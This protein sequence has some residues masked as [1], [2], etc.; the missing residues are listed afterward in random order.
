MIIRFCNL[1]CLMLVAAGTAAAENESRPA[2]QPVR[3]GIVDHQL[4]SQENWL[5]PWKADWESRKIAEQFAANGIAAEVIGLDTLESIGRLRT[6]QAILIPSDHNYPDRSAPAGPIA[7]NLATFVNQGGIYIMPFGAPHSSWRNVAG[8]EYRPSPLG[9][10]DFLGLHWALTA[11]HDVPG[12][13][14]K[15]APAGEKIALPKPTF[16]QPMATYCRV[17]TSIGEVYVTNEA[18]Q[19][20]LYATSVGH[21][22]VIHYPGGQPFGADVRDWLIA[23]YA[24]ILKSNI[25]F[26]ALRDRTAGTSTWAYDVL[27]V[28]ARAEKAA[29]AKDV[30]QVTLGGEWELAEAPAGSSSKTGAVS[31]LQWTHIQVPGTIQYALFQ[32]GKADN[33]WYADN[34]KKLQYVPQRDWYLR[35]TFTCPADWRGRHIRLRFDGM[36]YVGMVWLDGW[37]LGRHEGMAGGPTFDVTA[38]LTPGAEHEILVRLVHETTEVNNTAPS[39]VIKSM[40]VDG[41][42]YVWGNKFRSIGLWQPVRLVG[43]GLAYMEAPLVRTEALEPDAAQLFAQ[44]L[45]KNT[46]PQREGTIEARIVDLQTGEPVWSKSTRQTIPEG[47][48]FWERPIR[49]SNPRLWWPNGL[50]DQ[51]LYRLELSL[52]SDGVALDATNTRFGIRTIELKRNPAW[53]AAP[54]S[55]APTYFMDP[56]AAEAAK[57]A[58]ESHRFLFTVNGRPFYAKGGCWLTSDDLLCLTP[59]RESWLIRAARTHGTNLFR[60]NGGCNIFETEQFYNLCDENGILVWQETPFCWTPTFNVPKAAWREQF[61]QSV[62]R[63]RQHPSL[64]L[65][66]GGNEFNPYAEGVAPYLGLAREIFASL[67]DRPFRMSSPGGGTHHAYFPFEMYISDPNWYV[68]I[69]NEGYSFISEWSFPAFGNVSQMRRVIPK[70]EMERGPVGHNREKFMETHPLLH[71]RHSE[72]PNGVHAFTKGSWYGDYGKASVADY[73]EYTQMAQADVY[74]YVFEQ[75]RSQFPYKGGE[76]VWLYNTMAPVS[77]WNIIDWFGQPQ[78]SFYS[79][80]RANEPVHVLANVTFFS[81]AAGDTFKGSAFALNDAD[82]PINA[83]I[84]AR[85][86]DRNM[87]A[88]AKDSWT[89]AVPA[90]GNKSDAHPV[91]WAIPADTPDSYFFLELT[92][93]DRQGQ[94]LSRNTYCLN[95]LK[96]LADPATRKTW[97]SKPIPHGAFQNGPWLKPAIQANTTSL[98]GQSTIEPI[99]PDEAR[100]KLT[101]RNTGDK[102]AYP[103]HVDL[104]PDMYSVIWSDNYFWLAPQEKV[105]VTGLVRLNMKGLDPVTN[106]PTAKVA[107]LSLEVSAWN[108]AAEQVRK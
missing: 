108:A 60:L 69:A 64:A 62:L 28:S 58:D 40:A 43:T 32:A 31:S 80:K 103:V 3:V 82:E 73:V 71:D 18:G 72:V 54:R 46:G 36:D 74:G 1:A 56:L 20:C 105:T 16:K 52:V 92:M 19:P 30:R 76:T 85:I 8:G 86:L 59:E 42:S 63:I 65:Y 93:A 21:G 94:R 78:I 83:T 95:V 106:P 45:I 53:P 26:K 101:I 39:Q 25:D 102:P 22:A 49:L 104:K 87:Q 15:L 7:S 4:V 66:V 35:R 81:W 29:D 9:L 5:K 51:P 11:N 98:D 24:A 96:F 17:A 89:L 38:Q 37:F 34:Y 33:P 44:T 2:S 55:A 68:S 48:S 88:V 77:T 57:I 14:L 12:P 50:G 6:Y 27:P 75:W 97:Q 107:D 41:N 61:T 91:S 23:S 84:S 10:D 100:V 90:G 99:S 79:T 70:Q 13:A 47:I 67:D